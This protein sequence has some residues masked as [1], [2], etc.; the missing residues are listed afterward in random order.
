[1]CIYAFF[2]QKDL[3][4]LLANASAWKC[5]LK[6]CGVQGSSD[7]YLGGYSAIIVLLLGA[8]L[9]AFLFWLWQLAKT[10][11]GPAKKGPKTD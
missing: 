8:H 6:K 5:S 10:S 1:M 9:V 3:S 2:I 4:L 7:G 11:Q